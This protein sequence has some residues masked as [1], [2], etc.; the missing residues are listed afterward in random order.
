MQILQKKFHISTVSIGCIN[1]LAENQRHRKFF[2]NNGMIPS[3]SIEDAD[4]ILVNTCAVVIE[5]ED[6][7]IITIENYKKKYPEKEI[8]VSGCLPRINSKR[9]KSIH[10][11]KIISFEETKPF[12]S[13]VDSVDSADMSVLPGFQ[14]F[15]IKM[16]SMLS[17]IELNYRFQFPL[18]KNIFEGS[19]L[20]PSYKHITVSQG[21]LGLCTFCGIK[22]AKGKLVSR[23]LNSILNQFHSLLERDER[24]IW[25]LADDVGCWGEDLGA[26]VGVLLEKMLENNEDFNLVINF[27][28]PTYLIKH[29]ESLIKSFS[30]P[31]ITSVC[32]PLQS[33]S[34]AILESMK[35]FYDPIEVVEILKIIKKSNPAI[36]LRTNYIGGFPGETWS[37]LAQS[38]KTFFYYDAIY[39]LKYSARPYT[40]AASYT[41]QLSDRNKSFR[42][43]V[44]NIFAFMRHSYIFIKSIFLVKRI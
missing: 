8:Q 26:N 30:D 28:D 23:T 32:I 4:V 12:S 35:R 16:R 37:D 40:L 1:S 18:L 20:N 39:N 25:L 9:L 17:Y 24:K 41:N 34:G 33:G 7:S 22:K 31:R 2:E 43:G 29:R 42:T 36:C 14:L 5:S 38:I 27:L 15:I 3:V 13:E 21:C 11:G 44:M 6:T 19:I 10:D